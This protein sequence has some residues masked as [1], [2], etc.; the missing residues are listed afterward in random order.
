MLSPHLFV[1][2]PRPLFCFSTGL[3]IPFSLFSFLCCKSAAMSR[4]RLMAPSV[5]HTCVHSLFSSFPSLIIAIQAMSFLISPFLDPLLFPTLEVKGSYAPGA[6]RSSNNID[7]Q[8]YL[9]KQSIFQIENV[10][11]L[12]RAK[13]LHLRHYCEW[14]E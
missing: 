4:F 2:W 7:H 5:I 14:Y 3:C 9:F 11:R 12:P 8:F 13:T 10:C 6:L 1:F